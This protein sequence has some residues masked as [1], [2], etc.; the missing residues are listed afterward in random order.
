MFRGALRRTL[1]KTHMF[2]V[3]GVALRIGL[4]DFFKQVLQEFCRWSGCVAPIEEQ[5]SGPFWTWAYSEAF[6][7]TFQV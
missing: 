5:K 1:T 6:H 4:L 7:S 2:P 3:G